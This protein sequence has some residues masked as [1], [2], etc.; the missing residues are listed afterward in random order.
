MGWDELAKNLVDLCFT[1]KKK[2][3][4]KSED[5]CLLI[6]GIKCPLISV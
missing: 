5:F 4:V 3:G 1:L 2:D 6:S